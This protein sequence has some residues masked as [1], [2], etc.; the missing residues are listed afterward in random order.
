MRWWKK[1]DDWSLFTQHL[2]KKQQEI[3]YKTNPNKNELSKIHFIPV[4]EQWRSRLTNNILIITSSFLIRLE[5]LCY[6]CN[7]FPIFFE[8]FWTLLLILSCLDLFGFL[9]F[10]FFPSATNLDCLKLNWGQLFSGFWENCFL[11]ANAFDC[12]V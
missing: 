2:W 8:K 1:R 9:N 6:S 7:F 10:H 4:G 12:R 5:W 11:F 3:T